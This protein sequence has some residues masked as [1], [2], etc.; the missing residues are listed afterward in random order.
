MREIKK[1]FTLAEVLI[2]LL[3]I[4]VIASIVIP[5][6]IN[7]TNEAEY[8]VGVKKAYSDLSD[9]IK[10]IQVKNGGEV[11]IGTSAA[12]ADPTLL[13]NDFC[14]VMSCI[15]TDTTA[16]I[17]GP[18]IYK[19]YKGGSISFSA[20]AFGLNA[21]SAAINN[22]FLIRFVAYESCTNNYGVNACGYIHVDVNGTKGPNM[23]GKDLYGF[24]VSRKN[25]N[26]VY[27]ILPLGTQ[28]DTYTGLP[29][30]CVAGS[31][32]WGTSDGCTAK[33]LTDPDNMP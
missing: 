21:P 14:S 10:M 4:G 33:R 3:I 12:S 29:G 31:I 13:R 8:N 18:I 9:A 32:D 6:I 7:N 28:G 27:I 15:K 5:G 19:G 30:G 20:R 23:L 24:W 26:G 1:G 17:F 16:N 22:G 11:N 2:T 25:E